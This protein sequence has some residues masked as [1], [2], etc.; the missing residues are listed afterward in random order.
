MS[1]SGI[2]EVNSESESDQDGNENS[3]R[4]STSIVPVQKSTSDHAE[5]KDAPGQ[6]QRAVVTILTDTESDTSSSDRE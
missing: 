4:T 3:A 6:T 1:A 2:V 5:R